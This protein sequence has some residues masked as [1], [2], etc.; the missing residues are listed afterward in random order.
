MKPDEVLK[1]LAER[2]RRAGRKATQMSLTRRLE[3]LATRGAKR[4]LRE[5]HGG[6]LTQRLERLE[7]Q[8][9]RAGR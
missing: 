6:D 8:K 7:A 3:A 9:S 4:A 1:R 5:G 2:K